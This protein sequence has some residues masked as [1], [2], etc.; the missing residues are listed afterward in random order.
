MA[1]DD[2]KDKIKKG[3]EDLERS[4]SNVVKFP[5][6][7]VRK[8]RKKKEPT[9][10][11]SIE[12]NNNTQ[13]VGNPVFSMHPP[14]VTVAPPPN[15]I[16]ADPLL[17]QSIMERF[18]KLGELYNNRFPGKGFAILH[19]NFKKDFG[20]TN[21]NYTIYNQWP[22]GMAPYVINYLDDLYV[23]TVSGRFAQRMINKDYLQTKNYCK[24]REKELTKELN[25]NINGPEMI[26]WLYQRFMVSSYQ[27][28]DR[29]QHN[30]F[31][32]YLED[33]VLK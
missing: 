15:S 13:F 23:Y 2:L 11:Q 18:N 29:L 4:R 24:K 32:T 1:N 6:K 10:Y 19:G 31:V 3:L 28:L 5:P 25:L 27:Q 22:L 16:G 33:M 14:K 8:N 17:K 20:I 7:T 12:G 21:Q 9:I 30:L 26:Q